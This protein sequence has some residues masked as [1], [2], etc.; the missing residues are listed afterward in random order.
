MGAFFFGCRTNNEIRSFWGLACEAV[1]LQWS[2]HQH[3]EAVFFFFFF[4]L[5][6][7]Q[8]NDMSRDCLAACFTFPLPIFR[9]VSKVGKGR[10]QPKGAFGMEP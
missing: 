6:E 7:V 5:L 8:V 2:K 1:M 3:N 4:S 9:V 10:Q